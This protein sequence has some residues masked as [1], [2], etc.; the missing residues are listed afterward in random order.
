M[1]FLAGLLLLVSTPAMAAPVV[2]CNPN[3]AVVPHRAL[4]YKRSANRVLFAGRADVVIF[5]SVP[6]LGFPWRYAKC[7]GGNGVDEAYQGVVEMTQAEKAAVDA[8]VTPPKYTERGIWVGSADARPNCTA[9]LRG[10]IY[11][12]KNGS[13]IA[14]QC[15]VCLKTSA[16]AGAWA[17]LQVVFP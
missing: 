7:S 12:Q 10:A 17:E 15:F 6:D 16:D 8:S 9:Q 13:G 5:E 3:D 1:R 4:D 14:D 2:V 11:I